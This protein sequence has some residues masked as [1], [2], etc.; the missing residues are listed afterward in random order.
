MCVRVDTCNKV[1]DSRKVHVYVCMFIG[2]CAWIYTVKL[3]IVTTY[4]CDY[5]FAYVH[6]YGVATISRLLQIIGLFCRI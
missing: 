3:W 4:M 1:L 2:V 6:R 5:I